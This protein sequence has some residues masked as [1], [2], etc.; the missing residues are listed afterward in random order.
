MRCRLLALT[1]SSAKS[2]L[3]AQRDVRQEMCLFVNQT[4]RDVADVFFRQSHDC[5]HQAW[6]D[7]LICDRPQRALKTKR[8]LYNQP[9]GP[10]AS[11]AYVVISL[12]HTHDHCTTSPLPPHYTDASASSRSQVLACAW[13]SLIACIFGKSCTQ[14]FSS[15]MSMPKL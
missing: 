7:A 9:T 1:I 5:A 4:E 3:R 14:L 6:C 11:R 15:P 8:Y 2:A 13:S 12:H 10:T